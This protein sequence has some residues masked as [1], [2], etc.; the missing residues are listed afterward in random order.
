MSC[1]LVTGQHGSCLQA[2]PCMLTS[3]D[4]ACRTTLN[5]GLWCLSSPGNSPVTASLTVKF[6]YR[7]VENLTDMTL[8]LTPPLVP[9]SRWQL[10]SEEWFEQR[11]AALKDV[12]RRN[13]LWRLSSRLFHRVFSLSRTGNQLAGWIF[14]CFSA[15]PFPLSFQADF[16]LTCLVQPALKLFV[17]VS[18]RS[19]DLTDHLHGDLLSASM[20]RLAWHAIFAC[21][22]L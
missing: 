8:G 17:H 18:V 12:T 13:T 21:T 4:I 6:S 11:D 20:R 7:A 10:P 1:H 22:S 5:V 3:A 2:C 9:S 16:L 14:S 15:C 19:I